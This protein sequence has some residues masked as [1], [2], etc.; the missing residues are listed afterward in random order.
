MR[1][2]PGGDLLFN[3][4]ER[5]I[6][7]RLRVSDIDAELSFYV[8]RLWPNGQQKRD[9]CLLLGEESDPP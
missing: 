5:V 8:Y 1:Y 2:L 7:Q 3:Y 4:T 6:D 9:L